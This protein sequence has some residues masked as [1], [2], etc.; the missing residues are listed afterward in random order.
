MIL[1]AID[2]IQVIADIVA[3]VLKF[4]KLFV[5]PMGLF[6]VNWME[7]VL[8][9][10]PQNDLTVYISIAIV[11]VVLGLVVNITWPGN[12]KP[13][14]LAKTEE[15]DDKIEKKAKELDKKVEDKAKELE[16]KVEEKVEEIDTKIEKKIKK[17]KKKA[18]A[19]EDKAEQIEDKVEEID[20]K[21]KKK[22]KK[23]RVKVEELKEDIE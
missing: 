1:Q 18:K 11:I 6:M 12:K 21:I 19:L 23:A 17:A 10:F 16:E 13:G 20:T 9:F 2:F 15:I 3:A 8:Q 22:L 7:Y 14:F 4:L 5:N